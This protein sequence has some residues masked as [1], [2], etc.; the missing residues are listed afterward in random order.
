MWILI[1]P[2]IIIVGVW[3]RLKHHKAATPKYKGISVTELHN[4]LGV[5]KYNKIGL[6]DRVQITDNLHP[7]INGI[8]EVQSDG[9]LKRVINISVQGK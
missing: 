5:S 6:N 8:Y 9:H 2:L 7:E 3:R 1:I 4:N